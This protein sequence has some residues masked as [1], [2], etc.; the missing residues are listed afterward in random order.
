[1]Q[2]TFGVAVFKLENPDKKNDEGAAQLA[3][4]ESMLRTYEAMVKEN[5][6]AKN[7]ELDALLIKRTSNELKAVVD[8]AKCSK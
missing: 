3:G 1:M 7:A 4:I 5:E 6:K 2:F 8:A